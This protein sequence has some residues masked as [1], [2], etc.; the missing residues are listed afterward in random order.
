MQ[1]PGRLVLLGHPVEHSLS[2]TFQNAALDKARIPLRYEA[3]DVTPA[4]LAAMAAL[5]RE[6]N[7]AGNVTVPHKESFALLCD[8]RTPVAEQVGAVNTFYTDDGELVGDNTDVGGFAAAADAVFD[9]RP[10]GLI[11]AVI[12]AGGA[13]AAV[14]A[15]IER[16]EGARTRV[17]ARSGP[18]AHALVARF[19]R[20]ATV[21]NSLEEA[22]DGAGL[23]VNATPVGLHG[24]AFPVPPSALPLGCVAMDLTYRRGETPWVHACRAS[25]H[26]ATDGLTM[27]VEQ[28][29]LAFERWF[30]R[31][32]DRKAMWS[33]IG[34]RR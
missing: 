27:L 2:P 16:W 29:A 17:V 21:A 32:P 12:G 28:G 3:L 33:A 31:A 14:L 26:R 10:D 4:R 30:G 19:G 24:D 22:L 18:R 34:E 7:G 25:G 1:L 20:T 9:A 23:V 8:R 15:A 6:L 11:V 5:L 13:A